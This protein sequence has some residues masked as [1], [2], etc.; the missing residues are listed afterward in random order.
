MK[1]HY[2]TLPLLGSLLLLA[3]HATAQVDKHNYVLESYNC[4]CGEE[5]DST[6][7]SIQLAMRL[8][9]SL[10]VYTGIKNIMDCSDHFLNINGARFKMSV[11][12]VSGEDGTAYLEPMSVGNNVADL[13]KAMKRAPE[14]NVLDIHSAP[15]T[16]PSI[17]ILQGEKRSMQIRTVTSARI[18]ILSKGGRE[19]I[20]FE[21]PEQQESDIEIDKLVGGPIWFDQKNGGLMGLVTDVEVTTGGFRVTGTSIA[22]TLDHRSYELYHSFRKAIGSTEGECRAKRAYWDGTRG[23]EYMKVPEPEYRRVTEST[24]WEP[25]LRNM[26]LRIAEHQRGGIS[27]HSA[28]S[29]IPSLC[30]LGNNDLENTYFAWTDQVK[31]DDYWDWR[32]LALFIKCYS[33]VYCKPLEPGDHHFDRDIIQ[34]NDIYASVSGAE[35]ELMM[36]YKIDGRDFAGF[37]R[38]YY[39][40]SQMDPFTERCQRLMNDD[41]WLADP[42]NQRSLSEEL[43]EWLKVGKQFPSVYNDPRFRTLV[44]LYDDL[45]SGREARIQ[46]RIAGLAADG[47]DFTTLMDIIETDSCLSE[48]ETALLMAQV[49]E[50]KADEIE[51][52]N[53]VQGVEVI[54]SV[55]QNVA[56]DLG[57]EALENVVTKLFRVENGVGIEMT[58]I[59]GGMVVDR[60]R[61]GRVRNASDTT[62]IYRQGFPLGSVGDTLATAVAR[63]FWEQICKD[64]SDP[65]T[66]FSPSSLEIVGM[67]DAAPVRR[68]I[69]YVQACQDALAVNHITDPNTQLAFARA[70]NLKEQ[71]LF[72][73]RCDLFPSLHPR[74]TEDV[75]TQR[76]GRY[77]GVRLR[78]V[79]RRL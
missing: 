12:K 58:I 77:R 40:L 65:G 60:K 71:L 19:R 5:P 42:C 13:A 43:R 57:E 55:K 78:V 15:G 28:G 23:Y 66:V 47:M 34:L 54:E 75:S 76:G 73:D 52:E 44:R 22:N 49:R 1:Q 46:E 69:E 3:P 9:E 64:Y 67:A 14:H 70:W 16:A 8:D 79:M 30:G 29:G 33:N 20:V 38:E 10:G 31:E 27:S 35:C 37:I 61:T 56:R 48:A 53:M 39:A 63:T 24:K 2:W 62:S 17:Y 45:E 6:A 50:A 25:A 68:P 21:V 72:T 18:E 26:L 7:N 36:E 51:R 32:V 59:G 4:I 11:A 41:A 74:L